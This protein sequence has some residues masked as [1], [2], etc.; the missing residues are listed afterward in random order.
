M[1][2]TTTESSEFERGTPKGVAFEQRTSPPD[3]TGSGN[4]V[5]RDRST[6]FLVLGCVLL[7]CGLAISGI[8]GVTLWQSA[9]NIRSHQH[10]LSRDFETRQMAALIG[11]WSEQVALPTSEPAPAPSDPPAVT[12]TRPAATDTLPPTG[13]DTTIAAPPISETEIAPEADP[14]PSIL[15]EV[16]PA[17]GQPVARIVIPAADVDWV[18]IEGVELEHLRAGPGHMPWTPLPGQPGNAVISG[19]RTTYGAPFNKL[20]NL[21][22]GDLILVETLIGSHLYEV[23]GS[24]TV[25]PDGVWVTAP[26]EGGWLTLTTCHP[27]GRATE[28]LVVF[29]ALTGGP[30]HEAI[31]ER[32]PEP[33]RVPQAP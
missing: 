12:D 33:Y 28:R 29:A 6:V 7:A 25:P 5:P 13:P 1:T 3:A 4:R 8:A 16:A 14:K 24:T 19:H 2:E 9:S 27:E 26:R 18:V 22:P 21:Q 23:I 15:W 31:A 11:A 30:N 32:H 17:E 10:R 20:G